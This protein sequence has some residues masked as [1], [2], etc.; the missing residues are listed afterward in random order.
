MRLGQNFSRAK[1]APQRDNNQ[2]ILVI[3]QAMND[4]NANSAKLEQGRFNAQHINIQLLPIRRQGIWHKTII[5]RIAKAIF[6]VT[7]TKR[8]INPHRHQAAQKIGCFLHPFDSIRFF[9]PQRNHK[10]TT[11]FYSLKRVLSLQ[12]GL[13]HFLCYNERCI[14]PSSS[15]QELLLKTAIVTDT[16][17]SLPDSLA[18][19]QG[20]YL[21]PINIHFGQECFESGVSIQDAELFE[22]IAQEGSLPTT[23]APTPNQFIRAYQAAFDDGA[24]EVICFCVSSQISSTYQSACL[25]CEPFA[26][27]KIHVVDT[28]S[29]SMGQGF[30][31]LEAS[32]VLQAGGSTEEAIAAA[33]SLLGRTVIFGSLATLRFLAMSGRVGKLAAGMADLFE[34][35]PILTLR[36]GKLEMLERVRTQRR[37]WNRLVELGQSAAAGKR[38]QRAAIVEAS[39]LDDAKRFAELAKAALPLPEDLLFAPFTPG[40]SVHTG[41]GLVGICLVF[42]E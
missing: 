37:A 18:K 34:V 27:R 12:S 10:R 35:K 4:R 7:R 40:L 9:Q 26:G 21:V 16:D 14:Y 36:Q 2:L 6:G 29:L 33:Q 1:T 19:A 24:E 30:M 39:C 32:K 3:I 23:S 15:S 20:I 31:A 25:A 11:V 8:A 42:D 38:I 5:K 41:Q 22:R 17:A 28:Q 13:I